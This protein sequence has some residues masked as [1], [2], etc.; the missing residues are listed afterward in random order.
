M[1]PQ[2]KRASSRIEGRI[3]WFFSSCGRK[4][5]VPLELQQGPQGPAHVASG[6]SILH[7]SCEGLLWIPLLSL[8]WPKSA[9][10]HEA[11]ISGFLSSAAMYL[12]FPMEFPQRKQALSRL[13]TCKSALLS[14]WKNSVRF[15]VKLPL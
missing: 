2:W 8:P 11:G 13:E 12:V 3:S 10:G 1:T 7:L 15:P 14:S 9:S 5:G 4:L 6:N